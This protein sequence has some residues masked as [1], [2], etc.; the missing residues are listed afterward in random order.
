M[1]SKELMGW[2]S[3]I[4]DRMLHFSCYKNHLD[5]IV[6]YYFIGQFLLYPEV[7]FKRLL[8]LLLQAVSKIKMFEDRTLEIILFLL[9]VF[10]T[11]TEISGFSGETRTRL[12]FITV[13]YYTK[14][15]NPNEGQLAI[16]KERL[17]ELN[18]NYLH[19][20]M[21]QLQKIE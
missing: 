11:S 12:K 4:W 19:L 9:G 1:E 3:K 10:S 5:L 21:D 16:M 14:T 13:L 17:S 7:E 8:N 2:I 15:N 6:L 18:D 20:L